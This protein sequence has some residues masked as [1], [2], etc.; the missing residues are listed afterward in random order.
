MGGAVVVVVGVREGEGGDKRFSLNIFVGFAAEVFLPIKQPLLFAARGRLANG[1]LESSS[2]K[3]LDLV[4]ERIK[5]GGSG[6]GSI[7]AVSVEMS[8][9]GSVV[10]LE[11]AA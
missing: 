2:G 10:G 4:A 5:L 9:W 7:G 8:Q 3:A 1:A 6:H 11:K